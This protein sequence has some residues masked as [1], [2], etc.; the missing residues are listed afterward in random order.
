MPVEVLGEEAY[1]NIYRELQDPVNQQIVNSMKDE[2]D[3]ED[4]KEKLDI[5][6]YVLRERM[7][8]MRDLAAIFYQEE[9]NSFRD[10]CTGDTFFDVPKRTE[11][12][13]E[14]IEDL[15]EEREDMYVGIISS[16]EETNR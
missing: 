14:I 10:G 6:D 5:R 16:I 1:R 11:I 4:V 8:D 13:L 9:G 7:R 2:Q 15:G 12:A 3:F